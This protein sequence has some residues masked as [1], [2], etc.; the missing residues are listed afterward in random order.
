[1]R[2]T[3]TIYHTGNIDLL[4]AS[5]GQASWIDADVADISVFRSNPKQGHSENFQRYLETQLKAPDDE[6]DFMIYDTMRMNR[7]LRF[8]VLSMD[9]IRD[10]VRSLPSDFKV[11]Y[12]PTKPVD[13]HPK[14]S[15]HSLIYNTGYIPETVGAI[16]VSKLGAAW[17]ASGN[18]ENTKGVFC[19]EYNWVKPLKKGYIHD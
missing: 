15:F 10:M 11:L 9:Y 16:C 13:Q 5:L 6:V 2:L 7:Y 12:F 18:R 3:Y 4:H 17:L 8:K 19:M 1:M 14:L